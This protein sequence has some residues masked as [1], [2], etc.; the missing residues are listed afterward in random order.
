M[1]KF[2]QLIRECGEGTVMYNHLHMN[3]LKAGLVR[4]R[5]MGT[6][7]RGRARGR[8]RS[9]GRGRARHQYAPGP[10]ALAP[11]T[12]LNG[13]LPDTADQLNR[14]HDGR[15]VSDPSRTALSPQIPVDMVK[16]DDFQQETKEYYCLN[17]SQNG[18]EGHQRDRDTSLQ[19]Q[20]INFQQTCLQDGANS[21][22]NLATLR[23][24]MFVT[25]HR[26]SDGCNLARISPTTKPIQ[27][28]I[29]TSLTDRIDPEDPRQTDLFTSL[30]GQSKPLYRSAPN[31][32]VAF[33][34]EIV[35]CIF[36][37]L[38]YRPL[39]A[40]GREYL[41]VTPREATL[42]PVSGSKGHGTST[43]Q[44]PCNPARVLVSPE[45]KVEFQ[46]A[47]KT[48]S[49][50]D[51]LPV[52]GGGADSTLWRKSVLE[53]VHRLTAQAGYKFCPGLGL[54]TPSLR[55]EDIVTSDFGLGFRSASCELWYR[56]R[57]L[58]VTETADALNLTTSTYRL[59]GAASASSA[60]IHGHE[61]G[62]SDEENVESTTVFISEEYGACAQCLD[63]FQR[64]LRDG[65]RKQR[66]PRK[67]K[68]Q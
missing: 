9:R 65:R 66:N 60:R 55:C 17:L 7:G 18:R 47:Y 12:A 32:G 54:G 33:V 2:R 45:G 59:E 39:A 40:E 50:V 5:G 62:L 53:C 36:P 63:V 8:G 43:T 28:D 30:A 16:R 48:L 21:P 35:D 1:K 29:P 68:Q 57:Q 27:N 64:N 31:V 46:A 22:L 25:P 37:E 67:V 4:S 23:S 19:F 14:S 58:P 41:E 26:Q 44:C 51:A 61:G 3:L 15:E 6:A 52:G 42:L 20:Q 24:T 11:T 38:I 13:Q 49:T 56:S 34:K 10:T